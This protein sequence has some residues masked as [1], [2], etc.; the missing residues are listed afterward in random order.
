MERKPLQTAQA[1]AEDSQS[2]S[3]EIRRLIA[4]IK[5]AIF[6]WQ[7][8]AA[9]VALGLVLGVT[10]ALTK[11]PTYK[12]ETIILYRQGVRFGEEGGGRVLSL[13]TRLSEMLMARNR[14]EKMLDELAIYQET[15]AQ[16]GYVDAVE[17]FRRDIV[18]DA[19]ATDT[20]SIS[21][22]GKDPKLVQK[23]TERLADSLIEE[24][25]R[26]RIEQSR[27]QSEFMSA[28]KTRSEED[29]KAKELELAKF[30]AEHPEFALDQAMGK[31]GASIRAQAQA[32]KAGDP[33]LLA[34]E[35]QAQR[36]RAV[37]TGATPT[38]VAAPGMALDPALE[39]K[40]SAAQQAL[41]SA[42]QNLAEMKAKYTEQ[43][44]DVRAAQ[45]R[46]A[47]AQSEAAA[48]ES[49]VASAMAAKGQAPP[50]SA[51]G[52]K[53]KMKTD[54]KRLESQ[55]ASRKQAK[56]DE[57]PDE[58]ETVN[59]VVALETQWSRLNRATGDA[60]DRMGI[61]ERNFYRAQVEASSEL[62]GYSDQVVVLD[63][64]F[65]P[66]K[67]EKPGKAL[68]VVIAAGAS[69]AIAFLVAIVRALLDDRI[70]E[71]LDLARVAPVLTVVPRQGRR[72][73]FSRKAA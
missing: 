66:T 17:E 62:G 19:K 15:K 26:I 65:V 8:S 60:R 48:V 49:E 4:V 22:K 72:G 70:Y 71:E 16:G 58:T 18:W 63:P 45:G 54:L 51:D 39:S 24:N 40:R 44:P 38:P 57:K 52:A 36:N 68:I 47:S 53:D 14:L 28:E 29:L 31:E 42:Q 35:R 25:Q 41:Q 10:I 50:P 55:I 12:S 32:D 69:L 7:P 5:R 67:P 73:W 61:I 6:N 21:Y 46:L 59:R 30:L 20:F 13:G 9:I 23:V 37:L 3:R 56:T 1:S 11:K 34:L 43:H 2:A 27:T 33:A 64:A